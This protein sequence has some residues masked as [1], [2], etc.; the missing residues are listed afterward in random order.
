[1]LKGRKYIIAIIA[2]V[3]IIIMK[4]NISNAGTEYKYS[5]TEQGIEWSYELDENDNIVELKCTNASSVTGKVEI[6]SEIDGK[7]VTALYDGNMI[8]HTGVFSDC[9]GIT[10]IIF[11][12]T[13]K[14]IP[15]EVLNNCSGLKKVTIPDNVTEIGECAF[16]GC[17]GLKEIDLPDKLLKIGKYAFRS[18]SGIKEINLPNQLVSI[19]HSAFSACTGLTKLE[20]PNSVTTIGESAF[21]SCRGIKELKL[22]NQVT[23]ISGC[24]FQDCD[25][26]KSVEI[27]DSV[28]TIEAGAFQ[29]SDKLEKILIPDSVATIEKNAFDNCKNLTIYGNDGMASKEYAES[30]KIKFDYISNWN[31]TD[32][33]EDVTP[34]SVQRIE[35]AL[36]SLGGCTYDTNKKMYIAPT[37]TSLTINV[38]FSEII[39]GKNAP[40][41]AIKFGDMEKIELVNGTIGGST[42]SYT[43]SIKSEDKGALTT[44]S[45]TGGDLKDASGNEAVLTCP[46]MFVNFAECLYANGTEIVNPDNGDKGDNKVDDK[47]DDNKKDDKVNSDN[48]QNKDDSNQQT[49]VNNKPNGANGKDNTTAKEDLP[50]TGYGIGILFAV[51]SVLALSIIAKNKYNKLRDI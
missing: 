2:I 6:P 5:D 35:V 50:N 36:S 49:N 18:C 43:Y 3:A 38:Q 40:T 9:V 47:K 26:L 11:P 24:T 19:G 15:N 41:L 34:P 42:V 16:S 23:Q 44:V 45:L 8:W 12:N 28:T 33:G 10:E 51:I 7:K 4:P 39:E 20:I 25:S 32:D 37:G 48:S 13:I 31:K 22:S 30:N 27:P 29:Y 14:K 46:A 21:H 17:V 1:M